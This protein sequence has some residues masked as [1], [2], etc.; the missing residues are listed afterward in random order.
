MTILVKV[1]KR[2]SS[3]LL[4]MIEKKNIQVS[5]RMGVVSVMV[6][7]DPELVVEFI[8]MMTIHGN[9]KEFNRIFLSIIF[10]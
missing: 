5:I 3:L 7:W 2:N 1:K 8:G 10:H 9:T 6:K 4:F